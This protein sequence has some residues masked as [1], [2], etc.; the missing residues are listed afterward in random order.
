M[1]EAYAT[2]AARGL[3]CASRPVTQILDSAGNVIKDYP[4]RSAPR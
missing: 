1:A 3:H 2:F 4:T